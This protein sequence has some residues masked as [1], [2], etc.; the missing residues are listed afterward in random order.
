[1][2]TNI[3][4]RKLTHSELSEKMEINRISC[5]YFPRFSHIHSADE[6]FQIFSQKEIVVV[7]IPDNFL[8]I[9]GSSIFYDTLLNNF[10]ENSLML[11][12]FISLTKSSGTK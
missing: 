3:T 8:K 2:V 9:S 7:H 4:R 12:I 1:M 5:E 10:K 11:S 6:A